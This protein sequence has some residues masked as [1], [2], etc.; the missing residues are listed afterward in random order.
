MATKYPK[1]ALPTNFTLSNPSGKHHNGAE[2]KVN[3]NFTPDPE[4]VYRGGIPDDNLIHNSDGFAVPEF[5]NNEDQAKSKDYVVYDKNITAEQADEVDK[6]IKYSWDASELASAD[7]SLLSE[8]DV[9]TG[10][11]AL[12]NVSGLVDENNTETNLHTSDFSADADGWVGIRTTP[13]YGIDNVSDGV[14]SEN[15]CLRGTLTGGNNTHILYNNSFVS[16]GDTIDIKIS[17][18]VP[19]G[20]VMDGFKLQDQSGIIYYLGLGEN[21]SWV[22]V[23]VR[24]IVG[25]TL[26]SCQA[27]DDAS[28]STNGD[29]DVY[30]IKSVIVNKINGNN[31]QQPTASAQPT[32][33]GSGKT[34]LITYNGVDNFM[35][36]PVTSDNFQDLTYFEYWCAVDFDI[37][38]VNCLSFQDQGLNQNRIAFFTG[39]SKFKVYMDAG[40]DGARGYQTGDTYSGKHIVGVLI[41][42]NDWKLSIDNQIVS[43]SSFSGTGTPKFIGDFTD[44]ALIDVLSIGVS[45]LAASTYTANQE[46]YG[47]AIGGI[48]TAAATTAAE[49][50]N[51]FNM[52]NKKADLG[53]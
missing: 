25:N 3:T 37:A 26:F 30:Y 8:W 50:T 43:F 7:R 33:S 1:G 11:I 27:Y 28:A 10:A 36:Q 32:L 4:L 40:A 39:D 29:G 18:Y 34:S 2:T 20:Q 16:V 19:S 48:S 31:F 41:G 24:G 52:I 38:A 9:Q 21:G 15:D 13:D 42:N 14:R 45:L 35:S 6:A 22:D 17:V 53:L 46:R 5:M 23:E 51:I 44:K 47:L 49:Q 12:T